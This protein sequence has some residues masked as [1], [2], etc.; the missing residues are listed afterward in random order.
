MKYASSFSASA[1]DS[2]ATTETDYGKLSFLEAANIIFTDPHI[3]SKED[4]K[5]KNISWSYFRKPVKPNVRH[6]GILSVDGDFAGRFISI[7]KKNLH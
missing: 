4:S 2:K 3:P 5:N 7:W 6:L 1:F